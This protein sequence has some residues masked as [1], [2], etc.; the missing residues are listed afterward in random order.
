MLLNWNQETLTQFFEPLY[1]QILPT[2]HPG[3]GILDWRLGFSGG[4]R[5]Q[6][7]MA[8]IKAS[9]P[10]PQALHHLEESR[11]ECLQTQAFGVHDS[12][13]HGLHCSQTPA[14][15]EQPNPWNKPSLASEIIN[16]GAYTTWW[17]GSWTASSSRD[18]PI[19]WSNGKNMETK[20]TLGYQKVMYQPQKQYKGYTGPELYNGSEFS[21]Q[22][23]E[24]PKPSASRTQH[25][26]RGVMLGD[27]H[28]WHFQD[29]NPDPK[30]LLRFRHWN[31]SLPTSGTLDFG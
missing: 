16:S 21:F 5:H 11:K 19:S 3:T 24:M 23:Y 15:Y 6:N 14:S 10:P 18:S 1:D 13:S 4:E 31:P 20:K 25:S 28:F 22:I 17:S 30:I 29:P 8:F 27:N 7:H 12:H 2:P 26:G 9:T